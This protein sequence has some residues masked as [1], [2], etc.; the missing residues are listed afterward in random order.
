MFATVAAGLFR[1]SSSSLWI[2]F[3]NML[4][5]ALSVAED[6]KTYIGMT[7]TYGT[8]DGNPTLLQHKPRAYEE[9]LA[10]VFSRLPSM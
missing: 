5:Y 7:Q 6:D 9:S 10:A 8:V 3:Q 1:I 4:S 2:L